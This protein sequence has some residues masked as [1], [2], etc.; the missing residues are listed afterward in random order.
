MVHSLG[1]LS[2]LMS[3]SVCLLHRRTLQSARL[4][5]TS[6]PVCPPK[7]LGHGDLPLLTWMIE[8]T[9]AEPH[10]PWASGFSRDTLTASTEKPLFPQPYFHHCQ[11]F[12]GLPSSSPIVLACITIILT[13]HHFYPLDISTV[14]VSG[15]QN[16]PP[17]FP[18]HSFH[19]IVP[20]LFILHPCSHHTC[21][22]TI[23]I[24]FIV[25]R[26]NAPLRPSSTRNHSTLFPRQQCD[27]YYRRW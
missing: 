19:R 8:A 9:H 14:G 10:L 12:F 5:R 22:S 4:P 6:F 18:S 23:T 17:S 2:P 21:S 16:M 15:T 1:P 20:P 26:T 27:T 24:P 3:H 13:V 7:A 25:I 11:P